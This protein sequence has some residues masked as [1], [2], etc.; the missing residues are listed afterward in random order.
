MLSFKMTSLYYFDNISFYI[1]PKN[2]KLDISKIYTKWAVEN[3]RY[4]I[5]R[6]RGGRDIQKTKVGNVLRDTL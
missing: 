1:S 5:S 2:K 4:G 3:D 6:A